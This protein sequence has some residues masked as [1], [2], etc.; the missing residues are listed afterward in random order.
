M[1]KPCCEQSSL[2]SGR[3]IAWFSCGAASAVAAKMALE[4]RPDTVVIYNDLLSSEHPDNSRFFADVQRWL[5]V[6]IQ[7]THHP[8]WNTID[9]VFEAK[10][11]L[12]GHHGAPCTLA[13]K[14]DMRDLVSDFEDTHVL[15]FTA[16]EAD[17]MRKFEKHD[18]DVKVW[19]VL[20][21]LDVTKAD[22]LRLLETACIKLPAM[23][24][25][26]FEHNNCLGCVKSTGKRYWN[27]V[28]RN[29]PEVFR[30]RA[31]QER[32]FGFSL[33]K[34][35]FLDELPPDDFS[36]TDDAVDCGPFCRIE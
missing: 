14:R 28:R 12:A 4:R 24:D 17:R 22:C 35:C 6:T 19:W 11:F 25:L 20:E 13:L 36:G 2:W 9:E 26:G 23:Y 34:G 10:R 21:E 8:R 18:P 29:F 5:Q 1:K 32:R 27:M 30:R 31:E 3:T 15:G 16:D 7:Q 33:I